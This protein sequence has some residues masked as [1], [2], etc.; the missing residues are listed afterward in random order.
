MDLVTADFAILVEYHPILP[1]PEIHIFVVLG[2]A[3]TPLLCTQSTQST[4]RPSCAPPSCPP[5]PER[6]DSADKYYVPLAG[7]ARFLI[8]LVTP[9]MSHT[10]Y[11]KYTK[12]QKGR[13]PLKARKVGFRRQLFHPPICDP[14]L[15]DPPPLIRRSSAKSRGASIDLAPP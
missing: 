3:A 1:V 14:P 10:K 13:V 6:L 15:C 2:W 8:K 7:G 4:Q 11:P 5:R 12:C 9:L